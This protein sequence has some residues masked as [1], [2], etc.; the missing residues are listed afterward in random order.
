MAKKKLSAVTKV[1]TVGDND[2]I[3]INA[4]DGKTVQIKKVDLANALADVMRTVDTNKKGLLSPSMYQY[5]CKYADDITDLNSCK[6][7]SIVRVYNIENTPEQNTM[8]V[9]LVLPYQ[10]DWVIQFAFPIVGSYYYKRQ[11]NGGTKAWSGWV[12]YNH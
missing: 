2:Y 12:R 1:T 11:Y 4:S 5:I 6:Y 7:P 3:V 10:S 9:V 8:M